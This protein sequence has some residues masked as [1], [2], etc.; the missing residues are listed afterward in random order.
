MVTELELRDRETHRVIARCSGPDERGACPRV[1]PG[2]VLPCAG[3]ELLATD[4][5]HGVPYPVGL[6]MTLCPVTLAQVLGTDL[7]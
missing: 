4:A 7:N 6:T 2:E 3:C 1:A 5:P